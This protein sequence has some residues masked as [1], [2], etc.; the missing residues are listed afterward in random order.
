[1][2]VS[3]RPVTKTKLKLKQKNAV[4]TPAL[5]L[6]IE[7]F[8]NLIEQLNHWQSIGEEDDVMDLDYVEERFI[9]TLAAIRD[10][11]NVLLEDL[12]GYLHDCKVNNVP[13]DL[14]YFRIKKQLDES[15]F[16]ISRG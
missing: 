11:R 7:L 6:K 16:S 13:V 2:D 4:Q 3:V 12:E 1:M 5:T 15:T 10:M 8:G 14:N 9:E